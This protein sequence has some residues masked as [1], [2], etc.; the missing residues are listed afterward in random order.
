MAGEGIYCAWLAEDPARRLV[1]CR[2]A[3]IFGPGEGGNFT[4]LARLLEGGPLRL[5]GR[6][7]TIKACF[8][9]ENLVNALLFAKTQPDRDVLFNGCYPDRYTI[10]QIVE[11]MRQVQFGAARTV[12]FPRAPLM[13]AAAL[14]RPLSKAGLGIYPDRILKLVRSTDIV[15]DW[16]TERGLAAT[17]QLA[18]GIARWKA[19]T[20]GQ[21]D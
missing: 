9:V 8:Y 10:R 3:V 5:S 17:G 11:T 21:F 2:P 7:D 14:L 4:R 16:L 1:I 12:G 19:A 20:N 18:A 13:L 6:T 15:P